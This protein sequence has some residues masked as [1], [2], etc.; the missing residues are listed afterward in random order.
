[1]LRANQQELYV[2]IVNCLGHRKDK[3]AT[4]GIKREILRAKY[5]GGRASRPHDAAVRVKV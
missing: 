1:M 5:T 2:N 4:Q 3:L